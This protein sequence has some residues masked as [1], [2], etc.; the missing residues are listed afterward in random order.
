MTR[1]VRV[2]PDPIPAIHPLSED[3]VSGQ[4]GQ[5]Y[6]EVKETL[7]VPWMGVVM[8]AYAHY[9]AFFREL[10]RGLK[11]LVTSRPFVDEAKALQALAEDR[12][13]GLSPPTIAERLA[14][15]GY[16]EREI[17]AIIHTNEVFSHGNHLYALIATI[18]RL[19][20]EGG[21]MGGAAGTPPAFDGRHAPDGSQPFVLMEA[22]HADAPTRESFDDV[23]KVLGL[24]FV[25][26][27]YRAFA[28][29]PSYWTAAWG[30]LREIAGGPPH[31]AICQAYHDHLAAAVIDRLP[32]PGDLSSGALIGAAG[33]DAAGE[34]GIGEVME[35]CRLFQWLLPGLAVNVAYLKTQLKG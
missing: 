5:W 22:H 1:L 31:E 12:A 11:P 25:N 8:M 2:K 3:D 20:M 16:G 21:N 28:R 23:K 6:R 13:A 7:Q 30:D 17:E 4:R 14:Q 15:R 24:P 9:P 18:A 33:E 10:W 29:W 26:T 34:D 32:N 35:M 27:D 19:L